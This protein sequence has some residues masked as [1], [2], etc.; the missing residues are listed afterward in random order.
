MRCDVEKFYT[1]HLGLLKFTI[2]AVR[3]LP[4]LRKLWKKYLALES[5]MKILDVGCGTGPLTRTLWEKGVQDQADIDLFA[6]DITPAVLAE[7]HDWLDKKEIIS[8]R[9]VRA[10]LRRMDV[11][12]PA[13]WR[14]FDLI[15]SS[16]V[17]GYLNQD[18]LAGAIANFRRYLKP[19]G[20]LITF[21][22]RK[23]FINKIFIK[24]LYQ[25]TDLHDHKI[26][27]AALQNAGYS[28][29][30]YWRFPFPYSYLNIWGYI[31]VAEK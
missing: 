22:S 24:G 13:Y 30:E 15:C 19:N 28:N 26:F 2:K 23:N 4:A 25:A 7:F 9:T 3:Y 27:V 17:L 10:D 6:F 14:N 29:I 18:E 1:D 5:G 8:I 21:C 11:E 16:G 20:K 12:L 31:V